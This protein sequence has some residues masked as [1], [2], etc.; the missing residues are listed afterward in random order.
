MAF[1]VYHPDSASAEGRNQMQGTR[2]KRDQESRTQPT[3]QTR[4]GGSLEKRLKVLSDRDEL[5]YAPDSLK[6]GAKWLPMVTISRL[7]SGTPVLRFFTHK[8]VSDGSAYRCVR[9][10]GAAFT[11]REFWGVML[12]RIAEICDRRP[13]LAAERR[14]AERNGAGR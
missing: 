9:G 14:E 13:D 7:A 8:R 12:S 1:V 11:V 2:R 6:E 10:E 5:V 4:S 3:D